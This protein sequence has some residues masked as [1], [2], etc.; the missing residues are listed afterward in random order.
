MCQGQ[1]LFGQCHHM[2]YSN[3]SFTFSGGAQGDVICRESAI[4]S[5]MCIG[6]WNFSLS[7]DIVYLGWHESASLD[8]MIDD[9]CRSWDFFCNKRLSKR[10]RCPHQWTPRT[11]GIR[12]CGIGPS[13]HQHSTLLEGLPVLKARGLG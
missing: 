7:V 1:C 5:G 3:L 2:G 8:Y 12:L 4:E 11:I 9:G 13:P 10:C 6:Q